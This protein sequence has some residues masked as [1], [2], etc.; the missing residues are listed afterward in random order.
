MHKT[1]NES[2]KMIIWESSE[3]LWGLIWYPYAPNEKGKL[4]ELCKSQQKHA[5]QRSDKGKWEIWK[6]IKIDEQDHHN[7][8]YHFSVWCLHSH[9]EKSA[10]CTVGHLCS[11]HIPTLGVT[12]NSP[13]DIMPSTV[14]IFRRVLSWHPQ[15]KSD[16]L[17]DSV[18]GASLF[19]WGK[20]GWTNTS[21]PFLSCFNEPPYCSP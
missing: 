10:S 7:I 1:L 9:I 21:G 14:G 18:V 6:E 11:T 19:Q 13:L 17:E 5:M 3:A 8:S 20:R 12:A 4:K 15:C 2:R 16:V